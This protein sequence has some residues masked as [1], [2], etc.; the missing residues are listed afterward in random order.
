M[1]FGLNRLIDRTNKPIT[2]SVTEEVVHKF[3]NSEMQQTAVKNKIKEI[4]DN[5]NGLEK[6][7]ADVLSV[8]DEATGRAR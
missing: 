5:L 4:H 7:V 1:M 6:L 2:T 3:N 8:H